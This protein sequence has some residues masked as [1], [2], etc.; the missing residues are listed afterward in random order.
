MTAP[1]AGFRILDLS[2]VL[3]GPYCTML[4]GDLGAEVIKVERPGLGDD[5]R[6][7]G[8]PFVGGESAYYL[9]A[10]RNKKSLTVNLKAPAGQDIIRQLARMSD[11]LVENFR[12]GELATL[13]LGYEDL[14]PLNPGLVYCSITGYGQTG[15][16]K[17]LPGYDF[18]IQGRGGVMSITGEPEGEPMKVG[19]A[20]VD[21]TAGLF[22]ANAIQAA[23]LARSRTGRGQAI[24]ISLLDAQ[25]A[26]L[27]N[28]ASSYLVSGQRP[29][30]FG[31]AHP[32]IVPYQ[33]FH[34][35]D[36][37]FCLAVGND[38]QWRNLCEA[39]Q[40][41]ELAVDGRF[42][43]NP[44][45]VHHREE[46]IAQLQAIFATDSIAA[47]LQKIAAA[48]I[49]CGPV[50]TLDQVFTDPQV[51]ARGMVWTM[52]HPTAGEVRFVGSPLK[53]SETPVS[54]S[55]PPPLLGEHTYEVLTGLLGYAPE[56]V[57][58]L[59]AEGVV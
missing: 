44:Q 22:A 28:V 36:G 58:R 35:R 29:K 46:L 37:Y 24:D 53:L 9:C 54:S 38:G 39:L 34:A 47:W 25:V 33:T 57:D 15:P 32:A 43:T 30:R 10:N 14:K 52:P 8:P 1:L 16:D 20:V 26:W 31:N 5:T 12:V 45:R 18:I 21:I 3:A 17:D 50:Q 19:V 6:A 27:A 55:A 42:A 23:L 56:A 4:L 48:G 59:R 51:L 40:H 2:R 49:P 41:P 7:W 11:V 13:G